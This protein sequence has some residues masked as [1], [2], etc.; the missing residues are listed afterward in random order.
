ME[1][2]DVVERP[3]VTISTAVLVGKDL[4]TVKVKDTHLKSVRQVSE[5]TIQYVEQRRKG[6]DDK[7]YRKE[8][9]FI[10][11]LPLLRA[12]I[13]KGIRWLAYEWGWTIPGLG[14]SKD[15]FG[16]ALVS[17]IGSLGLDYGIGL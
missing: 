13:F 9:Q 2:G 11:N 7:A 12:W 17:N 1:W 3:T 4:T 5:E 15:V 14:L 6:K 10:E 8:A 16:S